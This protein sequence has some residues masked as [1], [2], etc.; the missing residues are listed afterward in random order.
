MHKKEK[1][2]GV[3]LLE[4]LLIKNYELILQHDNRTNKGS[5][6]SH[7]GFEEISLT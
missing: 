2:N 6:R 3:K 7:N 1:Q 5:E 4:Q